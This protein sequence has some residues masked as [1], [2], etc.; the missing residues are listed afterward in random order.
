MAEAEEGAAVPS[1]VVQEMVEVA[2]DSA[3]AWVAA[4]AVGVPG[5]GSLLALEETGEARCNWMFAHRT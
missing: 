5:A 2:V 3:G 1:V 4:A